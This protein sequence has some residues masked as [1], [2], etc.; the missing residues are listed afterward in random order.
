M[1]Q[2]RLLTSFSDQNKTDLVD[3]AELTRV[4]AR[5]QNINP[6]VPIL[7]T[8]VCAEVSCVSYATAKVALAPTMLSAQPRWAT[9]RLAE[10]SGAC[11][12]GPCP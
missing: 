5:V 7:P 9:L 8:Q 11:H 3:R 6:G 12:G 4:V 1:V 2:R 10:D